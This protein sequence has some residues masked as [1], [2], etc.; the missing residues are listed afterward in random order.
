MFKKIGFIGCG[1]MGSA[2]ARAVSKNTASNSIF[3]SNRSSAKAQSLAQELQ[4]IESTNNAIAQSCD[5]IFLGVKPQYMAEML[6]EIAPILKARNGDVILASMAAGLT[7]ADIRDMSGCDKV[8]RIMPNI[9]VEIGEGVVQVC[10]ENVSKS[11]MDM[12]LTL[13][14]SAGM[15]DCI[16]ESLI[17]AAVALSGCGTAYMCLFMEALADG[18][19]SCGLPRDKAI[20]YAAQ[21]MLGAGKLALESGK[22]PAVLK[23]MVCSPGGTTIQGVRALENG[24]IRAAAIEA[25]VAAYEKTLLLKGGK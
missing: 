7:V 12:F 18:A 20:R 3:L 19:V 10:S 6:S 15:V 24:G 9:A 14:S 5:L 22:H 25:V 23:D 4:G 11:E 8:I 21:T 1:N 16:P 13:L 2:L 17:D